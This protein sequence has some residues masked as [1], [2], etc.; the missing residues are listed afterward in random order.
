MKKAFLVGINNYPNSPLRGCVNDVLL[1]YKILSEKFGFNNVDINIITDAQATKFN[2]LNGLKKLT[3]NIKSG[4][5][6]YFHYSGHGSQ[7]VVKD[8]TNNSEPD[9]RDEILC[10]IDL[11]WNNPLRDNDLR[12]I[13]INIPKGVKSTVVL[14]SCHSGT[15][16][17]NFNQNL[18]K[19]S[20]HQL[21]SISNR[22]IPPPIFNM[23]SN[24]KITLDDDL[25]C[26][27]PEVDSKDIQTQNNKFLISTIEQ[28]DNILISGC[29][30][31]QTSADAF[32]N[33]KYHGALTYSLIQTLGSNNFKMSYSN[34]IS[35]VTITLKKL[36][37]QQEPQLESKPELFN[38]L[39]L[40]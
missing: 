16:L 27:F 25:N 31:N 33:N 37:F 29:K 28:S 40:G 5:I 9:G 12:N 19:D 4:D 15:G 20:N 17:R 39:F 35:A 38:A 14:D 30:D 34:L 7:V 3:S 10:P 21:H 23:L 32:M 24:P 36:G 13:Y 26:V 2:I 18:I 1:V 11:D 8:W 22:Y 6:I